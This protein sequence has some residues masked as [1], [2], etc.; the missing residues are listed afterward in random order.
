M[1]ASSTRPDTGDAAAGNGLLSRRVFLEGAL[2]AGA[3]ISAASAEP[4]AV[5]PWMKQ[6]GAG[7]PPYGQRSR[8]YSAQIRAGSSHF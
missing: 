7:F 6:P 4:L 8:F 2:G 3:A 1:D 5:Q